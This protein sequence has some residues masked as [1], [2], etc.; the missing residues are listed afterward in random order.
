MPRCR[1]VPL[2]LVIAASPAFSDVTF[3]GDFNLLGLDPQFDA[4]LGTFVLPAATAVDIRSVGWAAGG[5][6]PIV[7]LFQGTGPSAVFLDLNDDANYPLD[8]DSRLTY[9]SLD[10]GAYVLAITYAS[11]VPF[12][13]NQGGGTLG[14]GFIGLGVVDFSRTNSFEVD[15]S[16]ETPVPNIPEPAAILLLGTAATVLAGGRWRRLRRP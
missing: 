13:Y 14:D 5:F 8:L 7:S 4:Y 12:A 9:G 2:L 16:Y 10:A 15:V 6:D 11:N 1:L 3:S